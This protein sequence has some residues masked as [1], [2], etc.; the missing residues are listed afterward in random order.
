MV[1]SFFLTILPPLPTNMEQEHREEDLVSMSQDR[2]NKLRAHRGLLF[3]EAY[4]FE[5]HSGQ[6]NL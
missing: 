4:N 2:Q 5:P 6:K 3:S 1:N